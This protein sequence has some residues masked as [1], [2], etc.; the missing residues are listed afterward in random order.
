[1]SIHELKAV[2]LG[3][4][5]SAAAGRL[6]AGDLM[7]CSLVYEELKEKAFAGDFL[8]IK[9]WLDRRSSPTG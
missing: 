7:Y 2:Y 1:M 8:R 3:C 9:S 4:E 6:N 5:Q